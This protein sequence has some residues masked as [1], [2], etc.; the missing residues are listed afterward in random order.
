ML[1]VINKPFML[2][3]INRPLYADYHFAG[4]NYAE[5]CYAEYRYAKCR[6]VVTKAR[7]DGCRG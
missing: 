7:K 3:V 6:G 5:C 2:S 1:S 4:Y